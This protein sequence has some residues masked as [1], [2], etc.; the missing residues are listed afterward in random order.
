MFHQ[1]TAIRVRRT[2]LPLTVRRHTERLNT[3][4]RHTE[5][6]NT[7]LRHTERLNTLPPQAVREE[8]QAQG[9]G[10][11]TFGVFSKASSDSAFQKPVN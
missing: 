6:L 1:V 9:L 11:R 7:P 10:F 2:A 5:R 8:L 4:R 3:P